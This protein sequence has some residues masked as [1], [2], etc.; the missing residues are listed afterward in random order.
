MSVMAEPSPSRLDYDGRVEAF[1]RHRRVHPEVLQQLLGSGYFGPETLVLDVGSGTGNYAAALT[2]ATNCRISGVDPSGRMLK[3]AR[4]AAPWEA[5]VQATAESL[6][7]ADKSFDIVMS[8]DV[9]HHIGDRDAYFREAARVLRPGGQI[10][11]VTD[12]H[13]DIPRRRPLSSHFPET[14]DIELQRYPPVPRLLSEIG[15]AGF[16]EPRLVQVSH[17]Y[18]LADIQPY[19]EREFSSLHLIEEEAFR[20]GISRLEADLADGPIPCV[21]LYTIIWGTLPGID[22]TRLEEAEGHRW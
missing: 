4:D 9:I 8:T 13:D 2:A 18:D 7:F 20:R 16:V 12:S 11:T 5:L 15:H 1:V 10:V 6:P 21:S 22:S 17:E 14:V 3:Q 19:R